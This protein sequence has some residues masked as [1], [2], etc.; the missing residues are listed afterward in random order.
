[1]VI[2]VSGGLIRDFTELVHPILKVHLCLILSV[3]SNN[4]SVYCHLG[5]ARPTR[6]SVIM[7]NYPNG[8][9]KYKTEF[10]NIFL[11]KLTKLTKQSLPVNTCIQYNPSK[12]ENRNPLKLNMFSDPSLLYLYK[13][14]PTLPDTSPNKKND[15]DGF[16]F[17]GIL[18]YYIYL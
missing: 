1:M 16:Q 17:R 7:D 13:N 2:S 5:W 11:S 18:L 10:R 4:T 12:P 15:L 8:N 3:E 9:T 14:H 6:L